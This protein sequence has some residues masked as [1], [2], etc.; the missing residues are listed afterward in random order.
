VKGLKD[1]SR[2]IKYV[3]GVAYTGSALAMATGITSAVGGHNPAMSTIE[4]LGGL[5]M[6][7]GGHFGSAA[8]LN[9]ILENPKMY[10]ILG[11]LSGV[12]LGI[13]MNTPGALTRTIWGGG[14]GVQ[15]APIKAAIKSGIVTHVFNKDTGKVEPAPNS[16]TRPFYDSEIPDMTKK[17]NTFST[18][19]ADQLVPAMAQF[20]G[21]KPNDLN[22]R[23]NNPIN[24]KFAGQ[25]GATMGEKGFAK[26]ATPEAGREAALRQ[27]QLDQSRPEYANLSLED[28]INQ[29]HSPDSDNYPGQARLYA[30]T[31]QRTMSQN[32][33]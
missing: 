9:S 32:R 6:G 1:L 7:V 23:Q 25:P 33:P 14:Q 2:T 28:Y 24:L 30:N 18:L 3:K 20:E 29:K 19:P 15:S 12:K 16:Q 5:A 27:I 4:I 22:V 26:F 31:V 11:N 8:L 17:A 13:G 10:S 21:G